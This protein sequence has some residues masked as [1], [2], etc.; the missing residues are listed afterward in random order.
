MRH[1]SFNAEPH[2]RA[3]SFCSNKTEGGTGGCT[4][5][6]AAQFEGSHNQLWAAWGSR[7]VHAARAVCISF[8]LGPRPDCTTHRTL[9]QYSTSHTSLPV[10]WSVSAALRLNVV[11]AEGLA[12]GL[13]GL[14]KLIGDNAPGAVKVQKFENYFGRKIAV[15]AS[16][17]MYQFLVRIHPPRC[18][19]FTGNVAPH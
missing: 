17:S 18:H 4:V 13:Q 8:C 12:S 5:R 6:L 10:P 14:S 19:A 3:V 1:C 9:S 7:C 2:K 15:D 16:M 11:Q